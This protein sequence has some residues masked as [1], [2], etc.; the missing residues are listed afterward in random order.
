M[1]VTVGRAVPPI[2]T[3]IGFGEIET[4]TTKILTSAADAEAV[5]VWLLVSVK[6]VVGFMFRRR[7]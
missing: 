6:T 1:I 3:Y 7:Q 2:E 4:D 5:E